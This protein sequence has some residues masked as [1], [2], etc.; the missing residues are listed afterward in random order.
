MLQTTD[1]LDEMIQELMDEKGYAYKSQVLMEAV[2]QMHTKAFPAY[3]RREVSPE[4]R[5]ARKASEKESEDMIVMNKRIAIAEKLGG[6]V[7]KS[8]SGNVLCSYYKYSG[9]KRYEQ[10]VPISAID[11]TLLDS[12]YSP[13][14]EAVQALQDKGEVDY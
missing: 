5:A 9:R 13:S 7:S 2:I 6:K 14:K 11:E 4:E 3:S 1:R 8:S 12:Q 10:S